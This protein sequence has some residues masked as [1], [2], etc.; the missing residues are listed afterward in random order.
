MQFDLS[1]PFMKLSN[2]TFNLMSP[3]YCKL[4]D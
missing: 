4:R 1:S 2:F 3:V